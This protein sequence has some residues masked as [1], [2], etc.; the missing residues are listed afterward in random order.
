MNKF[1]RVAAYE[2]QRHVLRKGFWFGLLSV[3][4]VIVLLVGTIVI[5]LAL[6]TNTTPLGYV[7]HSGLLKN[8]VDAPP[9]EAP[10]QP[11]EILPF[12][13]EAAAQAAL[14]AGEIQAFYILNENYLENSSAQLVYHEEPK[15]PAR[16]QFRAF[17]VANLLAS[18]EPAVAQRLTQGSVLVVRTLDGS[19]Q[20]SQEE[21]F[22]ILLPIIGAVVFWITLFSTTGYLMQAVV[23]EKENRTMEIVA[24]SVSPNLL[25]GGKTIGII[26]IGLTQV[27]AWILF[28]VA[29]ILIGQNFYT[30]LRAIRLAPDLAAIMILIML[31]TF[32]MISG[33]MVAVGSTVADHREGQQIAGLVSLPIWIPYFLLATLIENPSSPMAVGLSLFPL[34]APMTILLRMGFTVIPVWE[35]FVSALLLTLTAIGSLWVAGRAF[36]MGML[37]YGKRLAWKQVFSKARI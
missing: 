34:T 32:V 27:V 35:I 31:P 37:L 21:W 10:D 2:Y 20:M 15:R 5:I 33:L 6:E 9:P 13:D 1:W 11:V 29:G 24:T 26:G 7:D 22:N 18:Q 17:I 3:P 14:D 8:P 30:P 19:R 16:S 4:F 23:E 36:R 12:A 25:I 28:V